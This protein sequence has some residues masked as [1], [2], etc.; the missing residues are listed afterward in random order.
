MTG[1][2]IR[3]RFLE[4]F[5]S[6]E[7]QVLPSAS[8]VPQGDPSTLF[9]SAGMQ[10]LKPYYLGLSQPPAPRIAT[11]QRCLRT[12]DIDEVG[13][14]DRHN[15]FF[16]MLGNFAPTG[17][18][19]KETAIPL[20]W[21]LVTERFEMPGDR[22]RVTIHPTDDEAHGIWV[23]QTGMTAEHVT[24][25]EDNWWGLGA[26]PCGPDSEIWWDR[27]REFGCGQE[28]CVPDHCDR[29][30]EF[31]NLVFPQYD[32]RGPIEGTSGE[33]VRRGVAD[34]SLVALKRPAIDTG[35]GLERMSY[36]LQGKTNIFEADVLEPLVAFVHQSSPKPTTLS[37]RIVAD[38][39]RAATFV[40]ADVVTP[41]NEGRGYVLRRLIRRAAIH[42]RKM[43]LTAKLSAGVGV[44]V[45]MFK[46]PYPE[47]KERQ[48]VITEVVHA[49][50]EKFNRTLEQGMEQFEKIAAQHPK[51]IPGADAFRLHDTFGFPLELTRELAA[52][53]GIELDEE[54]F[55]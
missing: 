12:G 41:S 44:A 25:L 22:L 32:Q 4:H 43:G 24:R 51:T 16:E 11:C 52:E 8:L 21:E 48:K 36:I 27:G 54:G 2:E 3:K 5:A 6:R 40:I 31:W 29:F 10:P 39:L 47:L 26:G 42:G 35:M 13:K 45:S 37:E 28:D 20:A 49:E 55:R 15:T 53:R 1:N 50:S 14:T 17:D 34:G 33:A 19:F 18:Y 23:Q 7:H 46:D 9:I 38:H 30:T